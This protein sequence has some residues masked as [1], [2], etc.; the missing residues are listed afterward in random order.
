MLKRLCNL[1]SNLSV[2]KGVTLLLLFSSLIY[3]FY[4]ILFSS[5]LCVT[6]DE[7]LLGVR[8]G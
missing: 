6:F 5:L 8:H 1:C 7:N 4:S 2:S 3:I